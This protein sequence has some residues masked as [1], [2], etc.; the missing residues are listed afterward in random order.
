MAPSNPT[1]RPAGYDELREILAKETAGNMS[2]RTHLVIGQGS[3]GFFVYCTHEDKD[4][5]EQATRRIRQLM[6]E[7][8]TNVT[9]HPWSGPP[10]L[11]EAGQS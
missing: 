9:V 7:R 11:H 5:G 4:A 2:W 3:C 6:V 10:R 8:F 1:R